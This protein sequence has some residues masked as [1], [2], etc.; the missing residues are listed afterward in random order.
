ML[1]PLPE[2]DSY[3]THQ[4]QKWKSCHGYLATSQPNLT[5]RIRTILIEWLYEVLDEY[6]LGRL[7]LH[8]CICFLD[9]YL[10]KEKHEVIRDNFQLIGCACL[11]V[12]VKFEEVD[13]LGVDQFVYIAD[14][15]FCHDDLV[16]MESQVLSV[17]EWNLCHTTLYEWLEHYIELQKVVDESEQESA[18]VMIDLVLM[19]YDLLSYP[20]WEV[21]FE[22]L[23]IVLK[24]CETPQ[25]KKI[26]RMIIGCI[27]ANENRYGASVMQSERSK[28]FLK[29]ILPS[30]KNKTE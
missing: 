28:V 26:R 2:D 29:E 24:R 15:V 6:T 18:R 9:Y 13:E 4:R 5:K 16:K 17:I 12:A 27:V 3:M 20:P 30:K 22:C 11:L 25:N 8:R 23:D 10:F 1:G 21:A 19:D 7:T 14:D